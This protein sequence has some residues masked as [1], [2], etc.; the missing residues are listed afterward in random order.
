MN[1]AS[2]IFDFVWISP[3]NVVTIF[4]GGLGPETT[5]EASPDSYGDMPKELAGTRVLFDE[6]P[7]P[8][9]SVGATRI[10]AVAPFAVS[11]GG[12]LRV[13][14]NGIPSNT[15]LELVRETAPGLF[16]RD[17]SGTGQALAV[18]RADGSLNGPQNPAAKG[19]IL[20]LYATGLGRTDPPGVAGRVAAA[21]AL[22]AVWA[23]VSVI[24][25]NRLAEV[26]YAGGAPGQA[27]G[28]AQVTVRIG[29]STPS[30]SHIPIQLIAGEERTTQLLTIAVE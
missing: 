23:P 26:L 12:R 22:P 7:I 29:E 16:A 8:L 3:G 24:V 4:G 17:G 15:F 19:S 2:S 1:A 21:D 13:E 14:R 28:F 9:L 30:G 6:R 10:E 18:H 27:A 5:A 20:D 25:G 11:R